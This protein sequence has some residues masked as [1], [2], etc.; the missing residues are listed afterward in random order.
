MSTHPFTPFVGDDGQPTETCQRCGQGLRAHLEPEPEPDR[1]VPAVEP[2]WPEPARP[3]PVYPVRA[4]R[5]PDR[6]PVYTMTMIAALAGINEASIRV[7]RSR[8]DFP[9]ADGQVGNVPYWRAATVTAWLAGRRRPGNPA[10]YKGMPS[11]SPRAPHN[12]MAAPASSED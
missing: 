8:G 1:P 7:Y 2:V 12:R 6:Q 4:M 10:W 5:G 3:L 11:P 9:A